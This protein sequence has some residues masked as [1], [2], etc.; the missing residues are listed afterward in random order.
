MMMTMMIIMMM[1]IM[2]MMMV[3]MIIIIIIIIQSRWSMPGITICLIRSRIPGSP[4]LINGVIE[5]K[6][7]N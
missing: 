6:G 3:M 4:H 5:T 2:I 7:H 1:M